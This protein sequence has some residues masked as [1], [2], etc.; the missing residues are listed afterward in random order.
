MSGG[1]SK[2]LSILDQIS[3]DDQ[4]RFP[5]FRRPRDY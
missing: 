3:D 4:T 5:A 2:T 1:S